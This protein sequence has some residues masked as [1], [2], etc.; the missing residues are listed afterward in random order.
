[1]GRPL[2]TVMVLNPG[3]NQYTGPAYIAKDFVNG[4]WQHNYY[5]QQRQTAGRANEMS[6]GRSHYFYLK[7]VHVN[8]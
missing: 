6:I 8:S 7:N 4:S 3:A 2:Q 1:M 5:S